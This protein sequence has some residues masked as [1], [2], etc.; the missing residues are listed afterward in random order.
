MKKESL[1][2]LYDL[3]NCFSAGVADQ[4]KLDTIH[5]V[6]HWVSTV[7][8]GNLSHEEMIMTAW[9][10]RHAG[11]HTPFSDDQI[12]EMQKCR[13]GGMKM[14][15]IATHFHVSIATVHK[16]TGYSQTGYPCFR[17]LNP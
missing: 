1:S 5:Q 14:K 12:S 3:L 7:Y 2:Q 4:D 8:G 15:D 9:N 10:I 6:M 16:Y 11:R 13:K 17:E